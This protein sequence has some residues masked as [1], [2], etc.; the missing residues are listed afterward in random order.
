M[1]LVRSGNVKSVGSKE[2]DKKIQNLKS[3]EFMGDAQLLI[4][5]LQEIKKSNPQLDLDDA[6][7]ALNNIIFYTVSVE[8]DI[9]Y[10][11]MSLS[12][13]REQKNKALEKLGA[14]E[15]E[16]KSHKQCQVL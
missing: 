7:R 3:L 2:M 1:H 11:N 15:D 10:A 16:L 9:Y 6:I 13:Y 8:S 12:S 14:V 4:G 5:K